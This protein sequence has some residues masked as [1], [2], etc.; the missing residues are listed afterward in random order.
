MGRSS[1]IPFLVVLCAVCTTLGGV[2]MYGIGA[3]FYDKWGQFFIDLYGWNEP[4]GRL[5]LQAETWGF[6]A[7]LLKAFVPC[8][9]KLVAFTLGVCRFPLEE[10]CVGSLL[11]RGLRYG[12]EGLLIWKSGPQLERFIDLYRRPLLVGFIALLL[13]GFLVIHFL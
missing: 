8:P 3:F 2:V 6:A 12:M 10:F 7:L 5:R 9:Y 4:F 1:R 11:G 13:G